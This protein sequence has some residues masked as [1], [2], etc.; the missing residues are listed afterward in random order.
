MGLFTQESGAVF[1]CQHPCMHQHGFGVDVWNFVL[2]AGLFL[3][4]AEECFASDLVIF[5]PL[6]LSAF[7]SLLLPNADTP[8]ATASPHHNEN[9]QVVPGGDSVE[10]ECVECCLMV[11]MWSVFFLIMFLISLSLSTW[12]TAAIEITNCSNASGSTMFISLLSF[13][14]VWCANEHF[15]RQ[16]VWTV[17]ARILTQISVSF[18]GCLG[19]CWKAT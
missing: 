3:L 13:H 9:T 18:P 5:H 4:R 16:P 6:F 10:G 12:R 15:R 19:T 11:V 17:V 2:T 14:S 7:T 1:P 8:S